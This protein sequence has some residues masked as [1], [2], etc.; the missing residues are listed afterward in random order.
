MFDMNPDIITRGNWYRYDYSLSISKLFTQYFSQG[1]LQSRYYN[2]NVSKLCY[3]YNPDRIIHSLPQINESVKDSWFVYLANNYV[4]FKDQISGVKNFSSRP[5][6]GGTYLATITDVQGGIIT[7]YVK[8]TTA[9]TIAGL[10]TFSDGVI[11]SVGIT[12]TNLVYNAGDQTIAGIKDFS[13]R[14]KYNGTQLPI[15]SDIPTNSTYVDMTT[16]QTVAGIKTFSSV[17]KFSAGADFNGAKIANAIPETITLTATTLTLDATTHN[18]KIILANSSSAITITVPST[19]TAGFNVSVIQQ[20]AGQVTISAGSGAT[21]NS[22]G[23]LYKTAGQYAAIS[24]LGL[25][26]SNFIMYG[27]TA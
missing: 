20:G 8:L 21:L 19:L 16:P 9:Q 15:A 25:G 18:G 6:F 2:P 5:Q 22:Y 7:D 23:N 13:S 12:G 17:P 11:S 10:K 27:N 14:P 24:I 3:V 4:E 26:G 1:N